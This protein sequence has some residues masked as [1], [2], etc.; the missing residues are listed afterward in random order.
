MKLFLLLTALVVAAG[1]VWI[2]QGQG[3]GAAGG[4]RS[5]YHSPFDVA[6][7]PDDK[8][9][10]ASDHTA[11]KLVVFSPAGKIVSETALSG[12]PSGLAWHKA[13]GHVFVAE[14]GAGTVA[15]VEVRAGKVVRRLAAGPYVTGLAV[16]ANRKLL[17][18]ANAGL[19]SISVLDLAGGRERT[20]I[21]VPRM[22]FAIAVTP[23][24]SLAVVTNSL[25]AM[26]GSD[27][28]TSS[29]ISIIDLA[30]LKVVANIRLP[31]GGANVRDVVVSPDG[32]WAYAAHTVGRTNLP[33]TQ[34]E[35]GWVNTNGLS[36]IDLAARKPYVTLLLDTP[37][38]G[39]ADPWGLAVAPDGKAL[40]V[41]LSGMH[42]VARIDLAGLHKKL[43][44][45]KPDARAG[46]VN[47]L[48]F[49]YRN[50]VILKVR[51]P[52]KGPRGLDVSSNGRALAAAVY[53]EGAVAMMQP[54]QCRLLKTFALGRNPKPDTVR[55]GETMFHDA[56][57]CFQGWLSCATCHP[58]GRNDGMNWDLLNDG[59]G[60]PKNTKSMVDAHRTPPVMSTGIR[61]NAAAAVQAGM[62]HIQFTV[63]P[64]SDLQAIEA[65]LAH[66]KPQPSPL[67][68][69][70]KLSPAAERGKSIFHDSKTG[71][72]ACHTGPLYTD[73]KR[74]NVGTRGQLDRDT[75]QLTKAGITADEYDTPT[76]LE[77]WRTG[78]YMHDGSAATMNDVLTKGNKGDKHG[79]TSHLS[80]GQ[81]EDLAAFLMSL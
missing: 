52:G 3:K 13:G 45:M 28:T 64:A 68:A 16:A 35:R 78:P 31:A 15:E 48:A 56:G 11:G 25:P 2:A 20:R 71:C 33:T 70:G 46:L 34:L 49:L 38:Q 22:P 39:A 29:Q 69:A 79:V 53:F 6:F 55:Y 26:P 30:A 81:I 32:K 14:C 27:P 77:L 74:Y 40:W 37:D 21:A 7:S 58:D 1:G 57:N 73:L 63:R 17:L 67:L 43:A 61:P 54:D 66:L 51:S 4:G 75:P 65:Y 60:N 18:A 23:D 5:A 24:E 72:A 12:R 50:D 9:L 76:L 44:A 8:L 19:N 59:L 62:R 80:A 10:A 41:T 42:Q 47:D 36:I